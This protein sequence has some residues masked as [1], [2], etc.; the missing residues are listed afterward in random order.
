MDVRQFLM[1]IIAGLATVPFRLDH[2]ILLNDGAL[3]GGV[4]F[5]GNAGAYRSIRARCAESLSV[6]CHVPDIGALLKLAS[7]QF[8]LGH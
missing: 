6:R 7:T 5:A 4:G 3:L 2:A 8:K 1:A